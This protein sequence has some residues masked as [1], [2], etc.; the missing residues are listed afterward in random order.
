MILLFFQ[1]RRCDESTD[2]SIFGAE[3]KNSKQLCAN[4][5]RQR[6]LYECWIIFT[7]LNAQ[8][9]FHIA[10]HMSVPLVLPTQT[11]A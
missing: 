10:K 2:A 7:I 8:T 4:Y 11:N 6:D 3:L 9:S 5:L 1:G